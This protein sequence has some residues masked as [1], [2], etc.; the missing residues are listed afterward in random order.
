EPELA[1][2]LCARDGQRDGERPPT[3]IIGAGMPFKWCLDANAGRRKDCEL[4]WPERWIWVQH[5]LALVP[6]HNGH[7]LRAS[8]EDCIL[9]PFPLLQRLFRVCVPKRFAKKQIDNILRLAVPTDHRGVSGIRES[10]H[11]SLLYCVHNDNRALVVLREEHLAA[12]P[13]PRGI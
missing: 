2:V 5:G 9:G 12:T 7:E 6:M 13:C 10:P 8:G 11:L 1:N 4:L 3:Q